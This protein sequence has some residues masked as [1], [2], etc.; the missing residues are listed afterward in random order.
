MAD[1]AGN[2]RPMLRHCLPQRD[3][4]GLMSLFRRVAIVGVGLIGG[5]IGLGITRRGLAQSVVGIGRQAKTLDSARE[6]GAVHETSLDLATGVAAADLVLICT[7]VGRIAADVVAAAGHL[8]D[9]LLSD[10]GSTKAGIVHDVELQLCPSGNGRRGVRFLGGHPIAGS[11]QKGIAHARDDLFDGRACVLTP[12]GKTDPADL[13]KLTEFWT[14][15]GARVVKMSPA[16]HDRALAA[17]SHA[18]HVIAAA[19]AAATPPADLSLAAG[20]WLDTTRIAAGDAS[21]WQQILL[22]NP[23][24]VL[25]GDRRVRNEIGRLAIGDRTSRRRRFGATLGRS[26]TGARCCGKLTFIRWPASP[27]APRTASPRKPRSRTSWPI[28]TWPVPGDI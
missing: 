16:D 26:Q 7:P 8:T 18:P 25:G 6:I 11:E 10:V 4:A 1:P 28:S 20:G 24:N 15:L 23:A 2:S 22:A 5:S 14:A 21:L 12:T 9:S 13:A 27:I 19:L 17:I 3:R